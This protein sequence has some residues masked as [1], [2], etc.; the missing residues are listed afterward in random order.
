LLAELAATALAL[1]DDGRIDEF[2]LVRGALVG[3][4]LDG[5][6]SFNDLLGLLWSRFRRR[7]ADAGPCGGAADLTA[8]TIH[9][10][11][12]IGVSLNTRQLSISDGNAFAVRCT[13]AVAEASTRAKVV[14][15]IGEADIVLAGGAGLQSAAAVVPHSGT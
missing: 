2:R 7:V 4:R 11:A 9:A 8:G 13:I 14:D 3:N 15:T 6:R 5:V 12:E 10:C 1:D